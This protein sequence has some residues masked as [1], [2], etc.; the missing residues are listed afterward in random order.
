MPLSINPINIKSQSMSSNQLRYD[1]LYSSLKFAGNAQY[2]CV[3]VCVKVCGCLRFPHMFPVY[4][5]ILSSISV[6]MGMG[7][8]YGYKI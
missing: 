4:I 8:N 1:K 3:S 2:V 6:L 5:T 7:Q